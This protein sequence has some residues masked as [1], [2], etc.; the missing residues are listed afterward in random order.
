MQLYDRPKTFKNCRISLK[1]GPFG[2]AGALE[3]W[4]KP[5]CQ[6]LTL[7]D[8]LG[9]ELRQLLGFMLALI[10]IILDILKYMRVYEGI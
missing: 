10:F 2:C 8:A 9:P 4:Y 5:M 1:L 7:G 3:T 6:I